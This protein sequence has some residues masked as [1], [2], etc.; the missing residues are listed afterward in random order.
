MYNL[1]LHFL[2]YVILTLTSSPTLQPIPSLN[3]KQDVASSDIYDNDNVDN[4]DLGGL[5]D[6][7]NNENQKEIV[8][9]PHHA[10]QIQHKIGHDNVNNSNYSKNGNGNGIGNARFDENNPIDG[11]IILNGDTDENENLTSIKQKLDAVLREKETHYYQEKNLEPDLDV[12]R[13]G[14]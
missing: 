13:T 2:L 9:E 1:P 12:S 11:I 7:I 5:C 10:T 14:P 3:S 8:I 6:V 4:C